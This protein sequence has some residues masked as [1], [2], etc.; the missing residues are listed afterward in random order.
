MAIVSTGPRDDWLID[1]VLKVAHRAGSIVIIDVVNGQV[2]GNGGQPGN[3]LSLTGSG[4]MLTDAEWATY[5]STYGDAAAA[6]AKARYLIDSGKFA[7]HQA[8]VNYNVTPNV[9]T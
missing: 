4:M 1:G 5:E 2:M 6:V 9:F 8:H 7:T 3:E